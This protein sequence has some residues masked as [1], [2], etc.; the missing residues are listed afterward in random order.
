MKKWNGKNRIMQSQNWIY[1]RRFSRAAYL[2]NSEEGV[3]DLWIQD[4]VPYTMDSVAFPT[5]CIMMEEE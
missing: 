3:Q 1:R 5:V 4:E 2:S